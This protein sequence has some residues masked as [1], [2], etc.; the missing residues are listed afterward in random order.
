MVH[1]CERK[2]AGLLDGAR[3]GPLGRVGNAPGGIGGVRGCGSRSH[4][5]AV[6]GL[7]LDR[8]AEGLKE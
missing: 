3:R 5:E 7:R 8:T 1:R 4:L 6:D 2:E